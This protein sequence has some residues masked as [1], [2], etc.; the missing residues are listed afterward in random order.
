MALGSVKLD[1]RPLRLAFLLKKTNK[2]DTLQALKICSSLWGGSLNY[3]VPYLKRNTSKYI[4]GELSG[5]EIVNGY[6]KNIDPDYIVPIGDID[7]SIIDFPKHRIITTDEILESFP[8]DLKPRY[9]IGMFELIDYFY[10]SELKYVRTE[11]LS[12]SFPKIEKRNE[13]FLTALVGD[14]PSLISKKIAE[15]Y[16]NLLKIDRPEINLSNFYSLNMNMKV[17]LRNLTLLDIKRRWM[18]SSRDG[19]CVFLIDSHNVQD[20]IDFWNLRSCGWLVYPV[21]IF[22]LNNEEIL[23]EVIN[24]I[25]IHNV[26]YKYNPDLYVSTTILKGVSVDNDSFKQFKK[27]I[28]EKAPFTQDKRPYHFQERIPCLWDKTNSE[29]DGLNGLL[30]DVKNKEYEF[31]DISRLS[32]KTLPPD[33]ISK[34]GGDSI[35]R[36]ANEIKLRIYGDTDEPIAEL[37]PF[38]LDGINHLI[39]AFDYQSW[40][41]SNEGLVYLSRDYLRQMNFNPPTAENVMTV[42]LKSKEWEVE[43]SSPGLIAKQMLKQ[44]GG[45]WGIIVLARPKL[46]KLLGEMSGNKCIS[47]DYFWG[48]I[49]EIANNSEYSIKAKNILERLIELKI[50]QLGL[51]LQC[52]VCQQRTWYRIDEMKYNVECTACLSDFN[53][54]SHSP[55]EMKWSFKTCGPF[56]LPNKAFG[57]YSVLLTYHFFSRVLDSPTT[58]IMSFVAK[59]ENSLIEADLALLYENS[60][61]SYSKRDLIFVECKTHARIEQKDIDRMRYIKNEFTEAYIVFSTL[62]SSLNKEE[63]KAIRSLKVR[64]RQQTIGCVDRIIIL[65]SNELFSD[66]NLSH[67]Y[68]DLG[69]KYEQ[70]SKP[71]I[72]MSDLNELGRITQDLYL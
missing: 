5:K 56:A 38:D 51:E 62:N 17:T 42:W 33:F 6:I 53:I 36:Y 18:S 37:L 67:T 20:I 14:L 1:L 54:P 13:L 50:F 41:I 63:K 27:N 31:N 49:Q 55:K 11:P 2:K 71:H 8:D 12:V 68:E 44:I 34:F 28:T 19:I 61:Y 35:V 48:R 46:I 60:K 59:K 16:D 23:S 70:Y 10:D 64:S 57:V 69:G 15:K 7:L 9:G 26:N 29:K 32:L 72:N 40:R 47:L 58:P 25:Q 3:I 52:P 30:L 21:P 22:H 66:W 4:Y 43:L 45:S 39:H 65:T 24:F